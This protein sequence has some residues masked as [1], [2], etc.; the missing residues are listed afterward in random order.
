MTAARLSIVIPALDAGGSLPATLAALAADSAEPGAPAALDLAVFAAAGID[1]ECIVVDGG[2]RDDSLEV[3]R[4]KGARIVAAAAG[5]GRQLHAGAAVAR[6][7]WLLFLHADTILQT[8]WRQ[9]VTAFLKRPD[10]TE[11][12]ACFHL[13]LD[14]SDPRARRIERLALWRTRR[15][16][17][18][19]GDQ[20]LLISRRLYDRL[21]GFRPLALMED[22]DLARRLGRR[23]LVLLQA[24]A[25]TSAARYRRDG[26]WLRPARNLCL[27]G[28]YF[29]GAPPHWLRRLYG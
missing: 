12:A 24:E 9:S 6:G 8:G 20:G 16:G 15:L 26:W 28:L 17:L 5:R 29:L 2:S 18:P 23:R 4:C 22:V 11:M 10:A 25:R 13:G 21:G 27:L 7:D 1:I 14:D 19:Y 3:A